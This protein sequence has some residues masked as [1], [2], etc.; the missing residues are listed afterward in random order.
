MIVFR[1]FFRLINDGCN[2]EKD[3][4]FDPFMGVGTTA[5]AAKKLNRN[6]LGFELNNEYIVA[7]EN[8]LSSINSLSKIEDIYVS[9]YL[10]NIKTIRDKDW[11]SISHRFLIPENIA[12]VDYKQIQLKN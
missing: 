1:R 4:V 3:I 2:N 8:K 5:I 7:A 10:N 11:N 6:Y 12:E 9:L